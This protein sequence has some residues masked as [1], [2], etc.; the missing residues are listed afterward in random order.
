MIIVRIK[1]RYMYNSNNPNGSH[2]YLVYYDKNSKQNRAVRLTHIYNK[3][4]QR[5]KQIK[6]KA[7]KKMKFSHREVPSGL[8]KKILTTNVYGKPININ[9]KDVNKNIYRKYRI[10]KKQQQDIFNFIGKNKKK[11]KKKTK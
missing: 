5:F 1:N 7:I 11:R 4:K 2:D 8:T 10:S 9:S 6:Q 3:D